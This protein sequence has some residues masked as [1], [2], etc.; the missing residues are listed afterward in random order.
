VVFIVSHRKQTVQPGIEF[1]NAAI[2]A[3]TMHQAATDLGLGSVLIWFILETIRLRPELGLGGRLGLPEDFE[4]LLGLA[5]GRYARAPEP[6][7]IPANKFTVL[8][9]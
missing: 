3:Y 4:P 7:D 2:A 1:C 9:R 6:R 5:A 8:R